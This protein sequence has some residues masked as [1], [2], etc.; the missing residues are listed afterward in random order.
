MNSNEA[1]K[2]E[3]A[4]RKQ[5]E[6]SLRKYKKRLREVER[7]ANIGHWERDLINDH[8][9]WSEQTAHIFGWTPPTKRK[10]GQ[11]DLQKLIYPE[12]RP[13]QKA[14]LNAVLHD[15]RPY[16][17]K[18]R[19]ARPDGKLDLFTSGMRS[20]MTNQAG[21]FRFLEP[22]R[23]SLSANKPKRCASVIIAS[24]GANARS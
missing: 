2:I 22:Y 24:P 10:F 7:L 20:S 17:V 11:A 3:V 14:A 12:D 4:R 16:D 18:Y 6:E 19:I 9:V 15:H 8:I 21:Q 1:L 23:I 5:L 13:A